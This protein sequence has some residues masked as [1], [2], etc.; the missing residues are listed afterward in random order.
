MDYNW[1]QSIAMDYNGLQSETASAC[2]WDFTLD[3]IKTHEGWIPI[4][5]MNLSLMSSLSDFVQIIQ[6][7]FVGR[8]DYSFIFSFQ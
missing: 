2:S 8:L 1:L 7:Y 4:R 6:T 5:L 3:S